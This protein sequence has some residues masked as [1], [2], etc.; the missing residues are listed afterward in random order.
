MI[1]FRVSKNVQCSTKNFN[2]EIGL[3]IFFFLLAP[4]SW[5]HL[6]IKSEAN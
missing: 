3:L 4:S 1:I 5:N 6:Y 2:L